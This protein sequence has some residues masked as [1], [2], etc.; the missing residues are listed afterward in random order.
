M[1]KLRFGQLFAMLLLSSAFG[2]LCQTTALTMEGLF[3]AA[4]AAAVQI[5]LCLPMLHLYARGFSFT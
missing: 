5:L 2:A 4:I 3:G 1:N